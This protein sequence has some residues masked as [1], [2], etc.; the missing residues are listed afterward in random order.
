MGQAL[1]A[2][3]NTIGSQELVSGRPMKEEKSASASKRTTITVGA[4]QPLG[5]TIRSHRLVLG[6][7]TK[8]RKSA[9]ASKRATVIGKPMGRLPK[10]GVGHGLRHPIGRRTRS[11]GQALPAP[12][13]TTPNQKFAPTVLTIGKPHCKRQCESGQSKPRCEK[14]RPW[15]SPENQK[16]SDSEKVGIPTEHGWIRSI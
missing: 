4:G 7:P 3:G 12:R 15:T 11:M 13:G 1:P 8:D 6:M 16:R 14:T 9:S 2:L 10:G 5:R